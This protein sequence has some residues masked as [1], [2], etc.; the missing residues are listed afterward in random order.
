MPANGKH[1]AVGDVVASARW[2]DPSSHTLRWLARLLREEG[3][4]LVAATTSELARG[5]PVWV[6]ASADVVEVQRLMAHNHIRSVAV[7]ENGAMVGMV[8]L[9][10]LA[11]RDD[12]GHGPGAAGTEGKGA[13]AP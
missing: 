11:L 3:V 4:N 9:V 10:D 13:N 5:T 12:L 7:L 6:D 1:T 2:A 8:D